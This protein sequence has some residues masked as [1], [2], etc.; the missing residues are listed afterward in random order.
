MHRQE[1]EARSLADLLRREERIEGPCR[2]LRRQPA[3]VFSTAKATYVAA[4]RLVDDDGM[5]LSQ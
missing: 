2:D 1:T 4:R 5:G 3:P